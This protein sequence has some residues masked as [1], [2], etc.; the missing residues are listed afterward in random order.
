MNYKGINKINDI[1][2]AEIS[3]NHLK[4]KMVQIINTD[5]NIN[6][7]VSINEFVIKMKILLVFAKNRI[8][9]K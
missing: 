8:K 3:N 6:E 1:D 2:K 4:E 9:K 5:I 7:I